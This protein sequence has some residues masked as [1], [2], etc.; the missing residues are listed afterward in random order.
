MKKLFFNLK[1]GQKLGA[2]F[3]VMVIFMSI[4]GYVGISNMQKLNAINKET[5]EIDLVGI[6]ALSELKENLMQIR[7]DVLLLLYDRDRNKVQSIEE[8]INKLKAENDEITLTYEKTIVTEDDKRLFTE[9]QKLLSDYRTARDEVIKLVNDN[10]YDEAMSAFPKLNQVRDNMFE[11]LNKD[12]QLNTSLAKENYEYSKSLYFSS[13]FLVFAIIIVSVAIAVLL[14]YAISTIISKQ[15]KK[16]VIFAES[17]GEG[18]LSQ[19]IDIDS[20]DEVGNLATALNLAGQNI[21]NLISG[22][23]VGAEDISA[24]SEELSATTEEISSKMEAAAESVNQITKGTQDLSATTEEVSASSEEIGSTIIELSKK[25][26]DSRIAVEEIK[27]RAVNITKK[28][29]NAIDESNSIYERQRTNL[30]N[31]IE[32]G[33]VVEQVKLMADSIADISAQTNL[34]ALNAAIEA[35]RAG[36]QG[37]G[38][39]VVADE[40]RKLA[41]QSARAVTS[42]QSMVVKVQSALN[43]LSQSGRDVLDFMLNNVQPT[44]DLLA[45]TGIQ[46]EKDAEFVREITSDI[47]DAT[48]Q[49]SETIEQVGSAIQNVSATAQESASSSEEILSG[50]NETAAAVDD[51]AKSAQ[52]QAELAEKLNIMISKFKI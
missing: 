41:E 13:R 37:R 50:I 27:N 18:D 10:K 6:R 35:A 8:D 42:I 2:V 32:E 49:M 46:Y 9:F 4:I 34:L 48:K 51:V 24:T 7:T 19:V 52:S 45:E 25:A 21:R 28:A 5:Y 29:A 40:V 17:I 20:K 39:A 33:K 16:V 14:A 22:I 26:G 11:V 43:N 44:Y 47:A 15:L 31:G 38:F 23:I 3:I 36:E 1:I 30:L 12:I